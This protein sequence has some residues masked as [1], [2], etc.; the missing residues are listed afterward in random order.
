MGRKM[1][2]HPHHS[3]LQ[4]G[5]GGKILLRLPE[6]RLI[7]PG[8]QQENNSLKSIQTIWEGNPFTNL[9]ASDK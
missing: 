8:T 1:E 2:T 4:W 9:R 3:Y 7:G 6:H 5:G